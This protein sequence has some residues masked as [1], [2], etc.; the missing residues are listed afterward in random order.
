MLGSCASPPA[1]DTRPVV[2]IWRQYFLVPVQPNDYENCGGIEE[3]WYV[4]PTDEDYG[5]I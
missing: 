4:E 5:P 2:V 1:A 3:C